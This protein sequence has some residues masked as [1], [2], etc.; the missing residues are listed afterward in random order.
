M[1]T[2]GFTAAIIAS[3]AQAAL[4]LCTDTAVSVDTRTWQAVNNTIYH[5]YT[6]IENERTDI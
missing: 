2:L 5:S 3:T 1:Q 4:D 6:L